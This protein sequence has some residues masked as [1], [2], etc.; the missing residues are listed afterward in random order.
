MSNSNAVT[1]EEYDKIKPKLKSYSD[2]KDSRFGRCPATLL[3]IKNTA[4]YDE[5]LER[6]FRYHGNPRRSRPTKIRVDNIGGEP[7]V[8]PVHFMET[9]GGADNLDRR[10]S[11]YLF[12][13]VISTL[14]VVTLLA[15]LIISIWR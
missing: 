13:E 11:I 12:I 1:R 7:V 9:K 14:F 5:Y 2:C 4:N 15:L 6:T 3:K 8:F 10:L